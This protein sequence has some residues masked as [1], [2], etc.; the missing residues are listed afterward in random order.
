MPGVAAAVVG[1]AVAAIP[2][3]V[4]LG[5]IMASVIGGIASFVTSYVISAAFGLNKAPK[6]SDRGGGGALQRNQD[7]TISVRQP[8]A[9]H[10]VIYG[11]VRVG[12]IISFLHT[13]DDNEYLHQLITIAGHEVNSIGQI[14]LDDLA[15]TVSSNT[16]NDTKFATFIDVYTGVGTTSGDSALHTALISNSGSKWTSAHKQSDRAKIYT[17]FKFDQDTFSGS[18]PNVTALVQGRKVFDPRDSSTAYSNNAALCIRDYLTNTSF[19]LG[20]PT[21]RINDTSFTTA[22]NIC[23]ENVS[24]AGGGTEDRY[25]CNGAFETTEA[26]KDVLAQL[27]SSCAGR[28]VYQ[29]GQWT[30]YAGAYVAPTITLDEDDLDGS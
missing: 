28:L 3:V 30:L 4:A 18:L 7:R 26:P 16:V 20:E 9:A 6:Q 2:S 1:A 21:S 27:L 24:L 11:Q 12:G 23:D 14:Y 17:R 29:G 8:I 13:T 15:A 19:G 10:R 5:P 25:T 22:A